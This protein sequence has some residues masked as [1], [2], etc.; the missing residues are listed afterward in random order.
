[1][2][3]GVALGVAW[4]GRIVPNLRHGPQA[5]PHQVKLV[6]LA[7]MAFVTVA[8]LAGGK[9][10]WVPPRYEAYVLALNLCGI[11]V[12]FREEVSAWCKQATW[13]RVLSLCLALLLIF[14]GYATQFLAIPAL[15]RK[16]YLGSYQLHRFVAEFYRAPVAVDQLGYV[17]LGNP[18]Y[19]L[20]LSGL[21]SE[22]ARIARA[23]DHTPEWMDGLLASHG[24]GLAIIDAAMDTAVPA[25]WIMVA[26]LRFGSALSGDEV[27]HIVI[28]A[29]RPGD[30][31]AAQSALDRFAPTL[32]PGV[33][34]RRSLAE[35]SA[36][37]GP[38]DTPP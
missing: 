28:Y 2:L 5:K 25:A 23:R 7:F 27:R 32:P 12:I 26:D 35:A 37:E 31:A 6:T 17:N 38:A 29:R 18:V 24:V 19:V 13:P 10:G 14:A 1:M 34:L 3:G 4:L 8:Q 15:A 20:D 36:S 22:A 30:V 21:G 16:E 11:A 9:I 33:H